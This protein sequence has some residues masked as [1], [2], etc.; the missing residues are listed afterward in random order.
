MLP[1]CKGN[2]ITY[3]DDANDNKLTETVNLLARSLQVIANEV[4]AS[5]DDRC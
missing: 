4:R 1:G 5:E 3:T 2:T